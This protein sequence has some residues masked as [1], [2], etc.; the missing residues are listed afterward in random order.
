M[1]RLRTTELQ[2]GMV[3][4]KVVTDIAGRILVAEGVTLNEGLISRLCQRDVDVVWVKGDGEEGSLSPEEI[5]RT[6]EKIQ[7]DL[8]RRFRLVI[9]DPLMGGLKDRIFDYLVRRE[10][11]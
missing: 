8:D 2:P 1:K 4:A 5:E 6:K 7:E 11:E 3:V 10:G 9:E